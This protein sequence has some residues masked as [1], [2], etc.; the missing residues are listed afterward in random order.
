MSESFKTC[1]FGGFNK[2]DVVDYI[3]QQSKSYQEELEALQ[4]DND[5]LKEAIQRMERE[6]GELLPKAK[7]QEETITRMSELEQQL[8]KMSSEIVTLQEENQKLREP[9]QEYYRLK[10]HIAEIEINAHHRTEEF[11]AEMIQKIRDILNAQ[12]A[13][14]GAERERYNQLNSETMQKLQQAMEAVE[15]NS[16]ENFDRMMESLQNLENELA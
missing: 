6:R 11:R 5:V 9:A 8:A 2:Q 12:R 1:M 16:D 13:W 7:Q 10:D 4:R 3:A 15:S 14:C